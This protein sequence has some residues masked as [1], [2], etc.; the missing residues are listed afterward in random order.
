MHA[1]SNFIILVKGTTAQR[2]KV[3]SFLEKEICDIST[4]DNQLFIVEETYE[5]V[6]IDDLA[7]MFKKLAKKIPQ[8]EFVVSGYVDCSENSGEFMDF[9]LICKDGILTSY[10]SD[11]EGYDDVEFDEDGD[12]DECYGRYDRFIEFE[13]IDTDDIDAA[14]DEMCQNIQ[15]QEWVDVSEVEG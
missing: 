13:E 14:F 3:A 9:G 11:W 15:G 6:W 10:T 12:A 5:V 2:K 8:I 4:E 7:A 1:S